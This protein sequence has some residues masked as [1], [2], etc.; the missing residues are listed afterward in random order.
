MGLSNSSS[1]SETKNYSA[2]QSTQGSTGAQSPTITAGGQVNFTDAGATNQALQGMAQVVTESLKE[3][4]TLA[5][6]TVDTSAAQTQLSNS[7]LSDVLGANQQLAQ[8]A[9]TGGATAAISQT[10]YLIWGLL[11]LGAALV[12][13]V[14]HKR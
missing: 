13:F 4:T 8:N 11:A 2:Q 10:N 3:L 12:F 7:T 6:K 9:Q 14:F 5:G 1:S